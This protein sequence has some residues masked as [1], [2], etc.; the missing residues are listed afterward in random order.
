MKADLLVPMKRSG[1]RSK[2][3]LRKIALATFF[4]GILLTLAA[5]IAEMGRQDDIQ[6]LLTL[7][8]VGYIL[9]ISSAAVLLL[10]LLNEWSRKN[11]AWPG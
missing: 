6:S 4:A 2:K 9:M 1:A 3:R 8:F 10:N 11:E 7:A 5:W